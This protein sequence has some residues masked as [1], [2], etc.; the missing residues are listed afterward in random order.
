MHACASA[1]EPQPRSHSVRYLQALPLQTKRQILRNTSLQG[2]KANR[3]ARRG[4][5]AAQH[6]TQEQPASAACK[7]DG[8]P[9]APAHPQ[10][11]SETQRPQ[12]STKVASYERRDVVPEDHL[13]HALHR[14]LRIDRDEAVDEGRSVICLT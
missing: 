13:Q 6:T 2:S 11:T 8:P 10:T 14:R 3:L 9:P 12:I 4:I 1:A 7:Q 5:R